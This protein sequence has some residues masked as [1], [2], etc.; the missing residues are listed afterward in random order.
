MRDGDRAERENP[1]ETEPSPTPFLQGGEFCTS[2]FLRG[3]HKLL[4]RKGLN[5]DL[6][7]GVPLA[8][9]KMRMLRAGRRETA[10]FYCFAARSGEQ[11]ERN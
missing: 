7:R 9:S 6:D 8:A 11:N 4:L 1:A 2:G 5:L 3:S 10:G